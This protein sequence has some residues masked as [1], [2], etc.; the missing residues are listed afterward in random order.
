M[1]G[2]YVER[3]SIPKFKGERLS[4]S[5]VEF[6]SRIEAA[7][8]ENKFV[9]N[10]IFVLPN[11]LHLYGLQMPAIFFYAEV[12][13]LQYSEGDSST[14]TI[15]YDIIDST[16]TVVK[17]CPPRS[18]RKGGTS[19]VVAEQTSCVVLA[20]GKY[21]LKLSVT[22]NLTGDQ[23]TQEGQFQ[24]RM[25]GRPASVESDT[26]FDEKRAQENRNL[27]SYIANRKELNL[28][29]DF[30]LEGKQ[31]FLEKFWADRDPTPGTEVNEFKE[32]Y[33]KRFTFANINFQSTTQKQG[34]K[35]DKGRIY[36]QHGPVLR[37]ISRG[38]PPILSP[39]P[40]KNGFTKL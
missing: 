5:Q 14:Y 31:A 39:I 18:F 2:S 40:G 6:A 27:I 21:T 20:T 22:D 10:G 3:I 12:Y 35:S 36:I 26:T 16:D 8:S 29:D 34:W 7:I 4:L 38:I 9:K 33:L 25:P 30:N 11:P 32:E 13:N 28:Y 1:E 15:Q 17:P 37:M 19:A 24:V 23:A